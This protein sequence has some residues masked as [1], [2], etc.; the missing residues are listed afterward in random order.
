MTQ[1]AVLQFQTVCFSSR[2]DSGVH[3][4]ANSAHVTIIR[5]HR[6]TFAPVDDPYEGSAIQ[7]AMNHRLRQEDHYCR[8]TSVRSCGTACPLCTPNATPSH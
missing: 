7:S 5:R 6:K 3:A 2:T 1:R 4:L 8:V